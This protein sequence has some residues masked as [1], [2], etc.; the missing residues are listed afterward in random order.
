MVAKA[1]TTIRQGMHSQPEH[2]AWF[3]ANQVLFNQVAAFYFEVMQAHEKILDLPTLSC[4]FPRSARIFR[5]CSGE[6]PSMRLWEQL[7]RFM[8]T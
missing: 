1:T 6:Q 4:H 5:P 2:A 8:P 7:A 3:A